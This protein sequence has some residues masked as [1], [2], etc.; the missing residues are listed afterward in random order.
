MAIKIF[1]NIAKLYDFAK[2]ANK[3]GRRIRSE[4]IDA[5]KNASLVTEK[6][7]ILWLGPAKKCPFKSKSVVDCKGLIAMPAFTECHTHSIFA[8]N[9]SSEFE[10]RNQGVSYQEIAAQGG[11]I[12]STVKATRKASEEELLV[13]AQK[14]VKRFVEQGVSTL[15]VKS[16]YALTPVGEQKMLRV[17]SNLKGPRIIKTYLGPHSKAD[18]RY[19]ERV[20]QQI[21]KIKKLADRVDIFIEKNYFSLQ[22]G[23]EYIELAKAH[24]LAFTIHA[25]QMSHTGASRLGAQM[26]A[27][28]VDHV[29]E[30]S[31]EDI[32]VLARS[33]T[34]AVLLPGADRYT[35]MPYP[36]AR[37][38]I[39][40]GVRLA[41]A[42]DFNPGTCPSQDLAFIGF[43]ARIEMKMSLAEI[44]SAYTYGAASALG[45]QNELGSLEVGK[46]ADFI[47]LDGVLE[48]LFYSVGQT[49]VRSTYKSARKIF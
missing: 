4:D 42:T 34:T 5:V 15:E 31:S 29:V 23:K 46:Q 26:G 14:R 40:S 45:L 19:F 21:P 16:G 9:R 27:Q 30:V 17:A 39:D 18:D 6:G 8:G 44:L 48:D 35:H 13:L 3:D 41:L 33:Q 10:L 22:E 47:L 28:S 11:G 7:R 1:T 38:L 32:D 25:D 20:L 49:P 12:A 2:V 37:K 24:E 43:L 36:P